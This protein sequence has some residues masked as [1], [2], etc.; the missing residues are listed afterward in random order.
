MLCGPNPIDPFG[1]GTGKQTEKI[2][3]LGLRFREKDLA[4]WG[5]V[6]IFVIQLYFWLHLRVLH[7][8]L[9]ATDPGTKVAWIGLY[10]GVFARLICILTA[11][12]LP[13]VIM[14]YG[15]RTVGF[16]YFKLGLLAP[17]AWL[18]ILTA[19]LLMRIAT[20]ASSE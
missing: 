17:A 6:I 13:L 12:M 11:C 4:S 10:S 20:K 15:I 9:T 19:F 1:D 2:E 3:L 14:L 16:S 18:A 5:A 7:S 8:R